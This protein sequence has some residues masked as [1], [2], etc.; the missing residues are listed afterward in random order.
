MGV[1]TRRVFAVALESIR[2]TLVAPTA[3]SD[4]V[5]S[6][7][8]AKGTATPVR[9][10]RPTIR[11]S[12][13]DVPDIYPGVSRVEFNV[14]AEIG[15]IP[16]NAGGA[17]QNYQTPIWGDIMRACG[18]EELSNGTG[19]SPLVYRGISGLTGGTAGS[20]IRHGEIATVDYAT[21]PDITNT[22][23]IGDFFPEDDLL[24]LDEGAA[25]QTPGT[26]TIT[27]TG[28]TSGRATTGTVVRDT[29]KI[30]AFRLR[31]DVPLTTTGAGMETLSADLFEDGKRLRAKGMMG[32]VEFIGDHGDVVKARFTLTGIYDS[33]ADV[34]VPTNA[35]ESHYIPPT[36]I[37]KDIR[38]ATIE[39][40]PKFYGRDS[41]TPYLNGAINRMSVNTGNDVQL[42]ENSFETTGFTFAQIVDRSP[43]GSMNPDEI[44]SSVFDFVNY[45]RTGQSIR[46]KAFLGT[47]GTGETLAGDGNTIDIIAPGIVF[48]GLSDEERENVHS[49]GLNFDVTGGDYDPSAAGEAPGNDNELTVLYR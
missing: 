21:N 6:I 29:S 38:L 4:A 32:N 48:T 15:G 24:V 49:W 23:V 18:F 5:P 8:E 1:A 14:L 39:A 45:L 47:F 10:E 34:A 37:G 17:A 7:R 35:N 12:L 2:G 42:R 33:M 31:S 25:P 43:T 20:P 36:F 16:P 11:L 46:L 30:V 41:F 26:G 22:T 13:T 27:I 9:V 19:R 3:S 44:A 28:A 40:S